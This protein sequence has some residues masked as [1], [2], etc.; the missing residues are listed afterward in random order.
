MEFVPWAL[1]FLGIASRIFVPWL[2]ERR[3]DPS[4]SWQWSYVWPQLVSFVVMALMLP[5]L[6]SDLADI[7]T[8]ELQFAFLVGWGAAD[9]GNAG[10]KILR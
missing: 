2:I 9:V 4:L 8:L 5:V 6:V 1:M 3:D 7:S 10:R